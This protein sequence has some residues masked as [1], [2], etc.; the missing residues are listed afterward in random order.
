MYKVKEKLVNFCH[1][2]YDRGLVSAA[3]GNASI[4]AGEDKILITPSGIS[5]GEVKPEQLI[6]VDNRGEVLEGD[7]KPS[8]ETEFHTGILRNRSEIN[9]VFHLHPPYA[10]AYVNKNNT[11]DL[12]TGASRKMCNDCEII[13]FYPAGSQE[14]AAEVIDRIKDSECR[15]VL[16]KEHGIITMGEDINSAYNLTDLVEDTA[17]IAAIQSLL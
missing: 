1:K 8:K 17:K 11:L 14:L 13:D 5:L 16:M 2:A 15:I 10:I 3:S 12:P 6:M 4:R 9:A 7:L